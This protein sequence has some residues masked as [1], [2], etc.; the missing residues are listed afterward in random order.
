[1]SF[2]DKTGAKTIKQSFKNP[3]LKMLNL[4]KLMVE[5]KLKTT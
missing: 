2:Y 4:I 1:M 5:I 3:F